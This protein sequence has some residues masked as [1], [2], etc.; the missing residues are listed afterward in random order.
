MENYE[1]GKL[2]G[3]GSF[4]KVY[5]AKVKSTNQVVVIK[6]I[7]AYDPTSV[8]DKIST[9][10]A[11]KH[12]QVIKYIDSGYSNRGWFGIVMEFADQG[13]LEDRRPPLASQWIW[14]YV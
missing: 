1:F 5:K 11:I 13:S 12:Q 8:D 3:Q 4:G 10:K 6:T 14:D 9:L 2:L 7:E